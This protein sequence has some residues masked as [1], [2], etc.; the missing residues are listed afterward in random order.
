MKSK[1]MLGF[2][3]VCILGMTG[4]KFEKDNYNSA[5]VNKNQSEEKADEGTDKSKVSSK[6]DET[7]EV[8]RV[9]NKV[10]EDINFAGGEIVIGDKVKLTGDTPVTYE[11]AN[12]SVHDPSVI[13]TQDG[14][15]VFG[16]H[17]A[18]AQSTDLINWKLIGSGVTK[19]N[20]IIPD[21]LSEMEEAFTWA[22]TN[23][24]WAPDVIQLNDGKYYMYYC[25]CEG[26]SP[27]ASLGIA[28][29]DKVEGPY[30]DLGIILKSGMGNNALSEDGDTYDA[31]RHPNVVD[32]C[33]YFNSEGRLW[34]VYGS[35]SGGIFILEMNPDTGFPLEE[36][37]G[38]KVM[39][40]NHVRI[41]GAY[42]LYSPETSYYYM[43]LSFGGLATDGGYNIRVVRSK[44]PDGPFYDAAG[45]DMINCK[46]A[47]GTFFSD[48]S[49]FKYGTKLMGNF[50][51]AWTEGEENKIRRGYLSPGH[52]SAYYEEDTGKYY[53]IFHTRF[54][55]RAEAHEVR[56]HEM[57]MN[58]D[59]W[60]VV[61]PYRYVG[62][63]REIFKEEDIPG[64]Y[65][66][67]NHG[68]SISKEVVVSELIQLNTDHSIS[69]AVLGSWELKEDGVKIVLTIVDEVYKG[70]VNT[71]WDESGKKNVVTFTALSEKGIAIWGSGLVALE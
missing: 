17:L 6:G 62:G 53:L 13:K 39:G 51:F 56:V 49:I 61:A 60:P 27:L 66:Y 31:T 24:F 38:K 22:K 26:S 58:E 44:S 4:C 50:R 47:N 7:E 57:Y 69:G 59:E 63:E 9:E 1:I 16:S 25:T 14:Y 54:E 55:A 45:N 70:L 46:G 20:P 15:Y 37:Y 68:N 12:V 5:V 43:F 19:N 30:K 71:E 10:N 48:G 32:P 40:G 36:G 34:M 18:G 8:S 29:S 52:N 23:T 64:I 3:L 2:A 41:E 67:I 28:I 65:K 11:F 35:Y 33:L 42:V 21:A